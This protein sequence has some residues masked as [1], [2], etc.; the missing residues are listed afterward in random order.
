MPIASIHIV[1]IGVGAGPEK[2]EELAAI[3]VLSGRIH[4]MPI[5]SIHIVAIGV[6]AGPEKE[7][8]LA[9]IGVGATR[10]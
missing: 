1:A 8:G 10:S 3:G 7:E 2:G 9:A 6:G 5:G 4:H